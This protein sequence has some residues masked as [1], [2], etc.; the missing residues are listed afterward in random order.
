MCA[1]F[2]APGIEIIKSQPVEACNP[3]PGVQFPKQKSGKSGCFC[4]LL[5]GL[6][7]GQ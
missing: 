7:E 6:G 1:M 5:L 3:E 4:L 2:F